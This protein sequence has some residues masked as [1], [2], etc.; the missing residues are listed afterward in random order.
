MITH[1]KINLVTYR[2]LNYIPKRDD[3]ERCVYIIILPNGQI[4]VGETVDIKKRITGGYVN[5]VQTMKFDGS[6]IIQSMQKLAVDQ[7]NTL[8]F[9]VLLAQTCPA[10]DSR[11]LESQW[12]EELRDLGYEVLN[13]SLPVKKHRHGSNYTKIDHAALY[14]AAEMIARVC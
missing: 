4:G 12:I 7:G 6:L 3:L 2:Y 14:R 13:T 9:W 1:E 8:N 11:I 5:K 10:A